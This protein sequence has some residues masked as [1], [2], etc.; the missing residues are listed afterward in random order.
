MPITPLKNTSIL[1]LTIH[2]FPSTDCNALCFKSQ[3]N[4]AKLEQN[5]F[6][7]SLENQAI[8]L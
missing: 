1:N 6:D 7:S 5:L 4:L 8:R 3:S 2:G